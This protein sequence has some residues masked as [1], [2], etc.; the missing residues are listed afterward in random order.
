MGEVLIGALVL[1]TPLV[2]AALGGVV[3]ERSGVI[4]FALEGMLVV[5]AFFAS[6]GYATTGNPWAGVAIGSA[7]GVGLGLAHAFASLVLR[8]NQIVSS[9]ALNLAAAGLAAALCDRW[10]VIEAP[11]SPG[12]GLRYGFIAASAAAALAV[13]TI[14]S[15]TAP[16]LRLRAAGENPEAARALGVRVP[17]YRWAAVAASGVLA[18][19]GGAYLVL[20]SLGGEYVKGMTQGRGYIAVAAVVLAGWRPARVVAVALGLGFVWKVAYTFQAAGWE[21]P[22]DVWLALPYLCALVVVACVGRSRAPLALG[23]TD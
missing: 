5:G 3:S 13:C 10:V 23:R 20:G 15:R 22:K 17:L 2:L 7:A 1:A 18:G 6:I 9:I 12:P 4:N 14:L 16:G 8:V 21:A 11:G 19:A